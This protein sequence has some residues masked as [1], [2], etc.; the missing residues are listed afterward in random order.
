VVQ[1]RSVAKKYWRERRKLSNFPYKSRKYYDKVK[2][3][4]QSLNF[5]EGLPSNL[6][7]QWVQGCTYGNG[8]IFIGTLCTLKK[9][10][11]ISPQKSNA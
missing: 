9:S 7:R 4:Y 1:G 2:S 10:P 5:F 6:L 8:G 3:F 11:N